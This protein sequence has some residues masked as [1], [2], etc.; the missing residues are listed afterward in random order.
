MDVYG[1]L[2]DHSNFYSEN[3]DDLCW[4]ESNYPGEYRAVSKILIANGITRI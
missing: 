2:T 3:W 4:L 1:V